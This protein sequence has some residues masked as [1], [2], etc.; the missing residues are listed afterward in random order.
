MPFVLRFFSLLLL[1]LIL[2]VI[3]QKI[4]VSHITPVDANQ[5][6]SDTPR[7]RK[8]SKTTHEQDTV[9]RQESESSWSQGPSDKDFQV[10]RWEVLGGLDIKTGTIPESLAAVLPQA[11]RIPG[12][13][14]PLEMN[15][16]EVKEFLLVP[17]SGACVHVPPPPA[18]QMVLVRINGQRAPR[19]ENGPVWVYG[20]LEL[21][22][23]QTEW[24]KVSFAMSAVAF[25][26]YKG[27]YD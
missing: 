11:N 2:G 17:T 9:Q 5:E 20:K 16:D 14:V 8:M 21:M 12:Y 15:S 22:K 1:A 10:L 3:L 25:K 27:G 18:N 13:V 6:M 19:R 26:P 23:T 7:I 4:M 24:G